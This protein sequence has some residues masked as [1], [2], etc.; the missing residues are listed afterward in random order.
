MLLP[1]LIIRG[2]WRCLR[3]LSYSSRCRV[4]YHLSARTRSR[5]A[6][7]SRRCGEREAGAWGWRQ[8]CGGKP[9]HKGSRGSLER[10]VHPSRPNSSY[11]LSNRRRG[12]KMGGNTAVYAI[13][14]F[15]FTCTSIFISIHFWTFLLTRD[16]K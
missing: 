14:N 8:V 2:V 9:N 12:R 6:T 11:L 10:S 16:N 15:I 3:E 1:G 5:T 7:A 4:P 13:Y